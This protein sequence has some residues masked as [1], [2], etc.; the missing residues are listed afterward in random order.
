MTMRFRHVAFVLCV[1]SATVV[2]CGFSGQGTLDSPGEDGGIQTASP[3]GSTTNDGSNT[4]DRSVPTPTPTCNPPACA[5]PTPPAGWELVLLASSRADAC[6]AGFDALDSIESPVAGASACACAACVTTGTNCSTGAL[7]TGFDTGGGGC[8]SNGIQL[9][10]N[11]GLCQKQNGTFGQNGRVDA[12]TAVLGTCTSASSA[13]PANVV[14]QAGRVCTRQASSCSD[15][16]C[17]APA[18]MKACVASPGD[19]ACPAG[20]LT[21][22]LVGSGFTLACPSCGCS[23][24]SATCGGK[25]DFYGQSDCGGS[26][27]TL[28]AGVCMPTPSANFQSTKWKPLI[29]S[30]QCATVPAAP[31]TTLTAMQTICCP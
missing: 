7:S 3:D 23:I 30:E 9:Q 14:T 25:M 17:G 12:P 20:A 1:A 24:T 10:T 11:G 6:P 4:A 13:V 18:S 2:A 15:R 16:A 5:L 19:V 21:K 28:T 26:A 27:T 8:G 29:V 22:H 31:K